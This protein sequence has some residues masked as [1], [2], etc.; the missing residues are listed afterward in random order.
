[1]S[2]RWFE[3]FAA[4]QVF[5]TPSRTITSEDVA[6]FARLTGDDNP[7]HR[8][9]TAATDTPLG[10]PIVHGALTTSVAMGLVAALGLSRGTLVALLSQQFTFC[11]PVR[12]GD[13]VQAVVKVLET[14][15][16]R[17]PDRGIVRYALEVTNQDNTTVLLGEWTSMMRREP[18]SGCKQQGS[19][20]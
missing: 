8:S 15:S 7:V 14:R 2:G 18:P 6:A 3:A 10:G 16:T 12:H 4:G 5:H 13:T 9:D 19:Q 1:M 11:H 17:H 20:A